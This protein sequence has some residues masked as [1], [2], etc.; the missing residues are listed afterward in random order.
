MRRRT[1]WSEGAR[2]E[3]LPLLDV[4]FLLLVTF[5]YSITAM[6]RSEAIPVELPRLG[7]A[8]TQ[9]LASVLVVTVG[10]DGAVFAG[11]TPVDGAELAGR[12]ASMRERDPELSVL[13]NADADARHRDVA[14][15]L[16]RLR[17]CGQQRVFLAGLADGTPPR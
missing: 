15:V 1:R 3:M 14:G 9:E 6:I 17:S 5:V 2:V 11:G 10:G 8:A 4:M 13:V 12:V 7:T 16:D